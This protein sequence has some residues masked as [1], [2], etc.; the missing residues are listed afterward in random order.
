MKLPHE[1]QPG[2]RFYY[3]HSIGEEVKLWKVVATGLNSLI[4]TSEHMYSNVPLYYDQ[5]TEPDRH[6]CYVPNQ[7]GLITIIRSAF[8]TRAADSEVA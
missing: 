6:F 8:S 5:M 2:D 3:R 1:L 4:A 7:P